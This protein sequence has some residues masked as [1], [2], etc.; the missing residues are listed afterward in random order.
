MSPEF[1]LEPIEEED[2]EEGYIECLNCDCIQPL[3][4]ADFCT[5][6]EY[7]CPCCVRLNLHRPNCIGKGMTIDFPDEGY[8]LDVDTGQEILFD[9]T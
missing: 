5:N 1:P 4:R 7:C 9:N 6:E 2:D 3:S 8:K